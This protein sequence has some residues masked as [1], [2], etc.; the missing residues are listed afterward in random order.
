[1]YFGHAGTAWVL[2]E[3]GQL[4]RDQRLVDLAEE[5]AHRLP[6]RWPNQDISHGAAG[7]GLAQLKFFEVTGRTDYLDRADLAAGAVASAA[8]YVD[9]RLMWPIPKEFPSQLAGARHF[10]FAHGVAGVGAFLLAA[11]RTIG[12][13]RYLDLAVNAAATLAATG[14]RD[15]G[16]AYWPAA[17]GGQRRTHWCSGS[18][19]VGT[20]LLRAWQH[21]GDQQYK[22]LAMQAATAVQ[23]ARWQAGSS[24]CHGLAGDAEFLLDLAQVLNQSRYQTWAR[25]LAGCVYARHAIRDR[26]MIP[27]DDTGTAVVPDYGVGLAGVLALL[28]R[29]RDGG[30]RM[31]FPGALLNIQPAHTC[32]STADDA[33]RFIPTASAEAADIPARGGDPHRDRHRRS[34]DLARSR[35]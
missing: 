6:L 4:L 23:R 18:S 26:R 29:L 14:E 19:G 9:G 2:L 21:T 5:L 8:G 3:A 33:G 17:P 35:L 20:F 24:Q 32:D 16:A 34:P 13:Q 1:M 15:G 30:P 12:D 22:E 11:G 7:A 10:G 25:E 28:L 27:P 31:W